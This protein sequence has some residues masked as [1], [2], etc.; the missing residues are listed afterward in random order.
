MGKE[1]DKMTKNQYLKNALLG[2][3]VILIYLIVP[4]FEALPFT[5]L[6]IDLNT[7]PKWFKLIYMVLFES[8]LL[9]LIIFILRE[10]MK[11]DFKDIKINHMKYYSNCIRYWFI[12]LGV[13]MFSNVIINA[14]SGSIA[15]NEEA[16]HNLFDI[17]P[18]YVFFSAVIFAPITEELVFRQGIRNIFKNDL[19]FIIISGLVFGSLH[20]ITSY[21]SLID[22]LYIIPYSAPGIAFAYMLKKYDNIFVSM[23]FHFM[24]NGILIALQF[25]LLIFG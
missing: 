17:S 5:I 3:L 18:I 22:L 1:S 2:I 4:N 20:V 12:S 15:N 16:I 19:I 8:V 9:L 7:I 10:K 11:N 25:F 14:I 6:G 21:T 13:M 24:H 23:G